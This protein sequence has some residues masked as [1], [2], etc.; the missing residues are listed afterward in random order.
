VANKLELELE[1]EEAKARY[2]AVKIQP[3]WV[4]TPGKQINKLF[5]IGYPV[6][7]LIIRMINVNEQ[8]ALHQIFNKMHEQMYHNTRQW[9]IGSVADFTA[10]ESLWNSRIYSRTY[11]AWKIDD[12]TEW[13]TFWQCQFGC[14]LFTLPFKAL[15]EN[16]DEQLLALPCLT[17]LPHETTRFALDGHL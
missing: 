2:R 17:V 9:N 12:T 3:Q 15:S 7:C 16:R 11:K 1:L 8:L 6:Y 13:Q 5:W 14:T 10:M 4:V